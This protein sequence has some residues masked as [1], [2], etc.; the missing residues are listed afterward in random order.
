[1]RRV[2]TIAA[3]RGLPARWRESAS[4][5]LQFGL[6]RGSSRGHNPITSPF[7]FGRALCSGRPALRPNP[8]LNR[9]RNG[10][11]P[12]GLISFWPFGVMPSRAG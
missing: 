11:P 12:T 9:T 6:R 10:M 5:D 7:G 8:S 2:P 3:A 1:M 4:G